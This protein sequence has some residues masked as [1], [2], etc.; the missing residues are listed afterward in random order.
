MEWS[1]VGMYFVWWML[2]IIVCVSSASESRRR[3]RLSGHPL[4][5]LG[6]NYR[7]AEIT[8]NEYDERRKRID[9]DMRDLGLLLRPAMR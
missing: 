3:M 1:F 6:G 2:S 4:G 9:T 5:T 7:A 8:T